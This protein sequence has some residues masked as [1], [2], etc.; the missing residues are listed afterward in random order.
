M[1]EFD[2]DLYI[3]PTRLTTM[4]QKL[5]FEVFSRNLEPKEFF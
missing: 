3:N 5:K 2:I 1:K 4:D